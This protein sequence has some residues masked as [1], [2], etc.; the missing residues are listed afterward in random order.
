MI[1]DTASP[2][3]CMPPRSEH[4]ANLGPWQNSR[5]HPSA[6]L[7]ARE[8]NGKMGV[9]AQSQRK[10]RSAMLLVTVELAGQSLL[11]SEIGS[12]MT[13]NN[14]RPGL[15]DAEAS[16]QEKRLRGDAHICVDTPDPQ[17]ARFG[18][19]RVKQGFSNSLALPPWVNIKVVDEPVGTDFR[20]SDN[21]VSHDGHEWILPPQPINPLVHI[22]IPRSPPLDEIGVVVAS[23]GLMRGGEIHAP[24]RTLL[25]ESIMANFHGG[26]GK[27]LCFRN[28]L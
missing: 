16:R 22:L 15:C 18:F 19:Q 4:F 13:K 24:D 14:I 25:T 28:S 5:F 26:T 20:H 23:N 9:C 7:V 1:K 27:K 10:A 8:G 2:L 12:W 6:L 11:H 3:I 21:A 17:R